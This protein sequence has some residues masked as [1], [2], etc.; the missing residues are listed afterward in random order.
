MSRLATLSA[1]SKP[2]RS[3]AIPGRRSTRRWPR[4]T[5][6]CKRSSKNSRPKSATSKCKR[7]RGNMSGVGLLEVLESAV[8]R[9]WFVSNILLHSTAG[10]LVSSHHC[11]QGILIKYLVTHHSPSFGGKYGELEGTAPVAIL[12]HLSN[13]VLFF[14]L[15][16]LSCSFPC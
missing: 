11:T 3:N 8:G 4:S 12:L 1:R 6:T 5:T 9:E 10:L 13:D 16:S 14:L 2:S 7:Y 15:Q